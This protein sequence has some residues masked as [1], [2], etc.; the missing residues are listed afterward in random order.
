MPNTGISD[1]KEYLD[2]IKHLIKKA[3]SKISHVVFSESLPSVL[4]FGKD[5]HAM[6][7]IYLRLRPSLP[8][9]HAESR[10]QANA[11]TLTTK[12][13]AED[14]LHNGTQPDKM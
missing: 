12:R 13:K 4:V 10:A 3:G 5:G 1:C 6:S 14:G 9:C 11:I 8:V 2:G 7:Q